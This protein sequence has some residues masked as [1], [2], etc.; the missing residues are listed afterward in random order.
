MGIDKSNVR[1]VVHGDL[2]K[3]MEG[4]YQQTGRA[5][6]DGEPAHCLLL[7]GRDDSV[8]IRY[9]IDQTEDEGQRLIATRQL[10]EMVNFAAAKTCRRRQILAYFGESLEGDNCGGC[11]I[12]AG[13]LE[14]TEATTEA[15]GRDLCEG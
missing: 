1:F 13:P 10:N 15:A 12:C 14:R 3:N 5:G 7:F 2:P 9:F 4:Y 11:D 8:K 6:R